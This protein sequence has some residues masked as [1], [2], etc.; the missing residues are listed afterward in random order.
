MLQKSDFDLGRNLELGCFSTS[1]GFSIWQEP[2]TTPSLLPSQPHL[3]DVKK[4]HVKS[5]IFSYLLLA[6]PGRQLPFLRRRVEKMLLFVV[7]FVGFSGLAFFL[8]QVRTV[9]GQ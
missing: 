1:C 5:V 2:S 4:L 3:F 7:I 6:K 8:F 9:P